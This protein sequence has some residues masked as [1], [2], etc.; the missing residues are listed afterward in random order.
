MVK[1]QNN[2]ISLEELFNLLFKIVKS[3]TPFQPT[4]SALVYLDEM[5]IYLIKVLERFSG[6]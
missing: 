5:H 1:L 4:K 6:L 3:M 2:W